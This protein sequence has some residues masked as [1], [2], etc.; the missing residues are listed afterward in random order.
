MKKIV[1][2]LMPVLLLASCS[3]KEENDQPASS[4][5]QTKNTPLDARLASTNPDQ[6]AGIH[7]KL[8]ENWSREA[9]RRMRAAT[10]SAPPAA[11]DTTGAELAVFFFGSGQGGDV[12]ANIDRWISQVEQPDGSPTMDKANRSEFPNDH[13][14]ITLVEIAGT[15][16]AGGMGMAPRVSHPGWIVLGAIVSAPEGNVFFKLTGPEKTIR[17]VRGSFEKLLSSITT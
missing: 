8:P 6:V 7:W 10:Y 14:K 12:E 16:N 5:T 3:K 11:G 9:D 17:T 13:C 1:L 4:E 2:L 15:Y